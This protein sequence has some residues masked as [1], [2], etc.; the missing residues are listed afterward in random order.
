MSFAGDKDFHERVLTEALRRRVQWKVDREAG[1]T[2]RHFVEFY[3]EHG[4]ASPTGLLMTTE[5][6]W[7]VVC[8]DQEGASIVVPIRHVR[9]LCYPRFARRP[10]WGG[11]HEAFAGALVALTRLVSFS[12]APDTEALKAVEALHGQIV[13]AGPPQRPPPQGCLWPETGPVA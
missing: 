4:Q 8:G 9:A 13:R 11:D 10:D 3:D 12:V 7:G 1:R 2:G 6:F 5:P